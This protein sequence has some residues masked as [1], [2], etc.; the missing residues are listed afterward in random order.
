[1][2]ARAL[3]SVLPGLAWGCAAGLAPGGG[4]L[5]AARFPEAAYVVAEG[6]SDAGFAEAEARARA[7]VAA[8]VSSELSAVLTTTARS[9][10]LAGVHRESETL[11][12][13]IVSRTTFAHAELIRLDA[14]ARRRQHGRYHALAYVARA[15]LAAPIAHEYD[16]RAAAF[17]VLAAAA[18]AADAPAA[19]WPALRAR[20]DSAFAALEPLAAAWRAVMR[21]E[22][23]GATDD[24][25]LAGALAAA[26]AARWAACVLELEVRGEPAVRAP[27]AAAATRAL[28]DLGLDVRTSG[29]TPGA[30]RL[31]LEPQLACTP[32]A[33]GPV[34]RL[35][36]RGTLR[37]PARAEV[38]AAL[39]LAD[40]QDAVADVRDAARAR[41]QLFARLTPGVLRARF[42]RELAPW[43]PFPPAGE[44]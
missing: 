35:T 43:L 19:G 36:L 37:E 42:A 26:H 16:A 23:A 14:R 15:E 31:T 17:R 27:L 9:S 4:G 34:C 12:S 13:A 11:E 6:V 44:P 5:P 38:V 24:R 33:L 41:D 8:Q 7:G 2:L 1:M 10:T 32:G 29:G 21:D 3:C 30:W 28:A 18:L 25:A 20:A 40:P 22:R 39:A